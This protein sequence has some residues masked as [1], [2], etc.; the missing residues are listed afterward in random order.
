MKAKRFISLLLTLILAFGLISCDKEEPTSDTESQVSEET[1]TE[2]STSD[3]N[4]DKTP[5]APKV[6]T[7]KYNFKDILDNIKVF[8]RTS[9][10]GNSISCDHVASGVEFNAYVEGKLTVNVTVTKG[11]THAGAADTRNDNCY[12][13]LYVDGVRSETRFMANKNTTT[14]LELA[15]FEEGG[16]HN[17]RLIKQTEPRNALATLDSVSFTGYFA[18]RPADAQYY[19]EFIGD[20]ITAGYGN[21][22]D[23]TK[24]AAVAETAIN[25]DST[26]SFAYLTAQKLGAD[27]TT[28]STSGIGVSAGWRSFPMKDLYGANSYYRSKTATYTPTR[29]PDVVVINL[30]TNDESKQVTPDAYKTAVKDLI[31]QVRANYGNVPIVWGYGMMSKTASYVSSLQSAMSDLGGESAGLYMC[32]LTYDRD[33]GASHPDLAAHE[34][35]AETLSAFIKTKVFKIA[36]Q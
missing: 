7:K 11:V 26:K 32:Q 35:S 21:L 30:G 29:T 3:T 28:V 9:A 22:T 15:S 14:T 34:S 23:K 8:G 5:E 24:G 18:E 17:F 20:S 27:H 13:T 6:V 1:S 10:I 19:V 2:E 36:A 12:F 16:V 31:Q 4:N 25:Q 33:A